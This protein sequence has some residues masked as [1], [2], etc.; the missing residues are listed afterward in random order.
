LSRNIGKE[1]ALYT[2]SYPRRAQILS[3]GR[4][5]PEME[6]L[7]KLLGSAFGRKRKEAIT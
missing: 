6:F 1:I 3:T 2:A 7:K 4:R 5:K